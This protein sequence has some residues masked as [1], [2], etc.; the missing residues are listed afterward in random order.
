MNWEDKKQE[1][2]CSLDVGCLMGREGHELSWFQVIK[3]G[4]NFHVTEFTQL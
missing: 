1:A 4:E 2:H 3:Q